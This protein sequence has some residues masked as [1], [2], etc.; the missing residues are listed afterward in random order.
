[1]HYDGFFILFIPFMGLFTICRG[2]KW[3]WKVI[4]FSKAL[5]VLFWYGW[6]G[7]LLVGLMRIFGLG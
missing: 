5:S 1:M 3:N 6:F 4:Q 7:T 2:G